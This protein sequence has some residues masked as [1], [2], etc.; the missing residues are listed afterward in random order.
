M[1]Y[2]Y[3]SSESVF[4]ILIA[5]AL[6]GIAMGLPLGYF[7]RVLAEQPPGSNVALLEQENR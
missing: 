6:F 2:N 5:A 7:A 4:S 3:S 1:K